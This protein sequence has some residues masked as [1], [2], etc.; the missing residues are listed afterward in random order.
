MGNYRNIWTGVLLWLCTG[1]LAFAH[2]AVLSLDQARA[3]LTVN[4]RTTSTEV[5]LPYGWDYLQKGNSGVGRFELDFPGPSA[6]TEPWGLY[7]SRFGNAYVVTFNGVVLEKN[8]T[9]EADDF[10]DYAKAPRLLLIPPNLLLSDNHLEVTIRSDSGRRSG[11]P[12]VLVGPRDELEPAYRKEF[13]L[14]VV[15]TGVL[16]VFSLVVGTFAFVLW[17]S[18]TDPRPELRGVRDSVYLYAALAE[19]AWAFFVAD[20]L[21]ERPPIHWKW[22]SIAINMALGIWLSSL[23]LFCHSIAGW[24]QHPL[25]RTV[26]RYLLT[27]VLIGPAVTYTAIVGP[28]PKLLTLWQLGFV[29]VFVPSALVF[30]FKATRGATFMHRLVAVVLLLNVPIALHDFYAMRLGDSFSNQAYLRYSATLFGLALGAI[31]IERFR[32]ANL[33]VRDMLDTLASRVQDKEQELSQ[34]YQSMEL[35]AREQERILER[36]RILRDMHDGVGS[37]ISSAIRQLQSGHANNA[38]VLLTLRDSLDQLKLSIDALNLPRGDVAGLLATLRYRLEPRF[39]AMGLSLEWAVVALPVLPRLDA[40]AMRQL[41]YI[42][43]EA[44]SNVMQHSQASVLRIE[45]TPTLECHGSTGHS[46]RIRIQDNG[47]GFDTTQVRRKGLASM[48]ERA[49]AIG[50]Q[51]SISSQPGASILE[52]LLA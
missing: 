4:G 29:L 16:S 38:E 33:R 10:S 21:I 37:H 25:T 31:A 27:M 44:L 43:F 32:S 34:S 17:V 12:V 36:S 46:V 39:R 11:V 3:E 52:I 9:L 20:G 24:D 41:Q 2:S 42:I 7:F 45:A 51:V 49:A 50:A 47:C 15:G 1:L 28:L 48:E 22:W 23:L 30:V 14:R 13:G 6:A 40:S 18:Q 19:F 26:R 5:R 8:G 35:I